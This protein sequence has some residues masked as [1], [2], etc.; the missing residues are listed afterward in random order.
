MKADIFHSPANTTSLWKPAPTVV[1]VHDV[2]L[3]EMPAEN[4]RSKIYHRTVQKL[5]VCRAAAV[6]C[7][8]EFT[9]REV[10][11]R[12]PVDEARVNVIY[13]GIGP[14]FRVL[15]DKSPIESARQKF[16]IHGD[17]I[18]FAGGE[19]APKNISNLILAFAELVKTDLRDLVLVVP[20]IRSKEILNKH[21]A[22]A[23]ALN[24]EG[25]VRFPG[26]IREADLIALMNGARVFVY[27][28]LSEGFGFPP[29]EAM[30]C[31]VPVAASNAT[32]IPE[33]VGDAAL[34]FDGLSVVDMAAAIQRLLSDIPLRDELRQRGFHR[35]AQFTWARAASAT[36]KIYLRAAGQG[37]FR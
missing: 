1:T 31:G 22:E 32:S 24:V 29:L 37:N 8:S 2:K 26:Y 36:L 12:F 16:A 35:V 28:S 23:K 6:I 30:A 25:E 14:Q 33:V 19:S 7:P 9:K 3:L 34:L 11:A 27:P 5:A 21:L 17:Y 18:L 4:V 15:T 13:N 20:G 10:L